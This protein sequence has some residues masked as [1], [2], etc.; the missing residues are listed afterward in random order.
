MAKPVTL[1]ER[2]LSKGPFIFD[3]FSQLAAVTT[4]NLRNIQLESRTS[5]SALQFEN[6]AS[7][8][9]LSETRHGGSVKLG[10][11]AIKMRREDVYW[12]R[13]YVAWYCRRQPIGVRNCTGAVYLSWRRL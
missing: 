13:L 12:P 8:T 2:A 1:G 4:A 11:L 10:R 9:A 5:S 6:E 3:V 7:V